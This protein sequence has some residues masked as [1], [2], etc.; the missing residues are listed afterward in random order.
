MT[1][2]QPTTIRRIATSSIEVTWSDGHRSL[3]PNRYLRENC[4]CALCREGKSVRFNLPIL[5]GTPGELTATQINLVGRYAIG[6]Q[7]SDRHDSGIYSY[8]TLRQLCPCE[9]CRPQAKDTTSP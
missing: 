7:W 2:P 3:Y 5:G 6:I 9:I 1:A 4:P 8:E